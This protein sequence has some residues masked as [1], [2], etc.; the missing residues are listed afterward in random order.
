[1]EA[2]LGLSLGVQHFAD[3]CLHVRASAQGLVKFS[4]S[5]CGRADACTCQLSAHYS[6]LRY[7]APQV[8]G[9]YRRWIQ[10]RQE[11]GYHRVTG[12]YIVN[13]T[14]K[15]H[16][17]LPAH[18]IVEGPKIFRRYNLPHVTGGDRLPLHRSRLA[19]DRGHAR[20]G[21]SQREM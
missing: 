6:V 19:K 5:Q 15:T 12:T 10:G 21:I 7:N 9:G 3:V 17:F 8:M 13:P 1:M 2:D 20:D 11:V 14:P 16:V 4:I 18:A